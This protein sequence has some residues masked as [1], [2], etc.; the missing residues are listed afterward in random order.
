MKWTI[1]KSVVSSE[2][3]GTGG[4]PIDS[5]DRVEAAAFAANA[6]LRLPPKLSGQA[7]ERFELPL[8]LLF[9]SC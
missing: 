5:R 1:S 3:R 8:P 7:D 2:A 4:F 9:I 6:V